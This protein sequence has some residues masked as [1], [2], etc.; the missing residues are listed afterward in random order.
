MTNW[1]DDPD[2]VTWDETRMAERFDKF[3]DAPTAVCIDQ[4]AL[5][6]QEHWEDDPDYLALYFDMG[7][8]D[9]DL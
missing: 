1:L 2:D 9:H 7:D 4:A 5:D 3:A 6:E 8:E